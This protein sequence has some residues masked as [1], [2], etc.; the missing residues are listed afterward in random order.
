MRSVPTRMRLVSLFGLPTIN[1]TPIHLVNDWLIY[2]GAA[3]LGLVLSH[4]NPDFAGIVER[5]GHDHQG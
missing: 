2:T 1:G 4:V 3:A 5:R